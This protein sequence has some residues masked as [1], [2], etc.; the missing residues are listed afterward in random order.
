MNSDVEVSLFDPYTKVQWR[1]RFATQGE[2]EN[3]LLPRV[4]AIL[5]R[6]FRELSQVEQ[7]DAVVYFNRRGRVRKAIR[8]SPLDLG[9]VTQSFWS[10]FDPAERLQWEINLV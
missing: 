2:A 4:V 10:E 6:R 3:A 5:E 9:D 7:Q 1:A 8:V